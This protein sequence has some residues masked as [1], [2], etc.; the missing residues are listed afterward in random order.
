MVVTRPKRKLLVILG[1]GSSAPCGMPGVAEIDTL[2]KDWNRTWKGPIA[3]P[4]AGRGTFNDVWDMLE[5]YQ[6]QSSRQEL[7][8][9]VNFERVLGEMTALASWVAPSPFGNALRSAVVDGD[10]GPSFTWPR[11]AEDE[12]AK[13]PFYYRHLIIRQ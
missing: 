6:A 4:T 13:Q 12:R 2:M 1:A 9:F 11:Q 8:L 7:G 10:P 5:A 3:Y